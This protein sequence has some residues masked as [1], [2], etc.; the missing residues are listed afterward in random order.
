VF[1]AK[2]EAGKPAIA[3]AVLPT[4]DVVVYTVTGVKPGQVAAN[5]DAERR[6][7]AGQIAEA[8]IAA[9]IASMRKKAD[10]KLN[11]TSVFE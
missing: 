7:L 1:R 8:D 10:I 6:A 2:V 9:Y 11:T 3:S 4:G 5:P